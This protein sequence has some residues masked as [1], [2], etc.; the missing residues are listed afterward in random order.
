MGITSAGCNLLKGCKFG[1]IPAGET[2]IEGRLTRGVNPRSLSDGGCRSRRKLGLHGIDS[3]GT[4][5]EA[6]LMRL[7][8]IALLAALLLVACSASPKPK[9]DTKKAAESP[10]SRPEPL[11]RTT[12]ELPELTS[13]PIE[14]FE[15]V[16]PKTA[17]DGQHKTTNFDFAAVTLGPE[18]FGPK[19]REMPM[20]HTRRTKSHIK[21]A[22][23][24]LA[25]HANR[26]FRWVRYGAKKV[27]NIAAELDIRMEVDP[28]G[29]ISEVKVKG[30]ATAGEAALATCIAEG[31]PL[32]RVR[33]QTARMTRVEGQIRFTQSGLSA[34]RRRTK[35]PRPPNEKELPK[36]DCQGVPQSLPVDEI[37]G[38]V[39]AEY[40]DWDV[41]DAAVDD[42]AE[43]RRA[44]REGRKRPV[45][46][47]DCVTVGYSLN[48]R[49]IRRL[50]AANQGQYRTCYREALGRTPDLRG[51][52]VS[53][54]TVD[55]QEQELKV[56][57]SGDGDADFHACMKSALEEVRFLRQ[58]TDNVISMRHEFELNPSPPTVSASA[59]G[60]DRA[61]A[62]MALGDNIGAAKSFAELVRSATKVSGECR[63][64]L[65]V[66]RAIMA[67]APWLLDERVH[68]ASMDFAKFAAARGGSQEAAE[69]IADG[70]AL[71]RM[72]ALW[73]LMEGRPSALRLPN[74]DQGMPGV[75][76]VM[77]RTR[78]LLQSWPKHPDRT[79]L[80]A[81]LAMGLAHDDHADK[82]KELLQKLLQSPLTE[83]EA[84]FIIEFESRWLR[85]HSVPVRHR[86]GQGCQ[87][88]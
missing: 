59:T 73:P 69:C 16:Q 13:A 84:E 26:C 62:L 71:T 11:P 78:E 86:V 45:V 25:P 76:E 83:K 77:Q 36:A 43:E 88:F 63:G 50:M 10:P 21:M 48:K 85:G 58:R 40:D 53:V 37:R 1:P 56:S 81:L 51:R 22:L 20:A 75:Y 30:G 38:G 87:A 12:Y 61:E 15:C 6:F 64:R 49:V 7:T 18:N 39:L 35:R 14:Q 27:A 19:V 55:V 72:L 52:L 23:A 67:M 24:S 66:L 5:S 60:S 65:G 80:S 82:A 79:E 46:H 34:P 3:H 68:T 33:H 47:R 4:P 32:V 57:V 42:K 44:R 70:A 41:G 28:A 31:L 74:L 9:L 17:K 29:V 54:M 8:P 2:A